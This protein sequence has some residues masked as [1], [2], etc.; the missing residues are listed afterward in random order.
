V[1]FNYP[2][3]LD[4]S[5]R[6]IVIIG[7][8]KVAARKAKLLLDCG[9][10]Q[11]R[12]IAP[13]FH[14]ELPESVEKIAG[15]YLPHHL[16]GAQ[17]VFAATDRAEVNDQ[18]VRDAH[19]RGV[20]VCRADGSEETSGDFVTPALLREGAIGVTISAGSP[21]LATMVRDEL[22]KRWDPRWTKM[23]NAM[24]TMRPMILSSA[25]SPQERTEVFRELAT[26]EALQVLEAEGVEGVIRWLIARH[27]TLA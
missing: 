10:T 14:S 21:A 19:E 26:Q 23:G 9:A 13:S 11:L 20:L 6:R 7:G 17:L 25:L 5:T 15:T 24:Q 4:V 16:D 2:L 18:V 12:V 3:M 1:A 22:A 27:P 8:G